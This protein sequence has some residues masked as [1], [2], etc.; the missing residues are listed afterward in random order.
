MS[1]NPWPI[2]AGLLAIA[3]AIALRPE[4]GRYT[5]EYQPSGVI[6]FDTAKARVIT[7]ENGQYH[8]TQVLDQVKNKS[9][10]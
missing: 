7:Y 2:F 8:T 10:K 5:Y 1:T 6:F 4:P 9:P 3:A